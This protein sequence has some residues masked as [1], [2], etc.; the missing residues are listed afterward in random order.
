MFFDRFSTDIGIDLGTCNTL[1]YVKG[2]GIVIDEP[3]VIA[4]EKGT[5]RVVAVGAEAKRMLWK[6]PSNITAIRPL[7][8]GVIADIDSTEKM[9]KYFINKIMPRHKFIKSMRMKI[10]IPSCITEVERR[11]VIEAAFKAGAKEVG[12]IEESLAAAI[13][14]KIPIY[15]PAGHMVCDIGGGTTEVSVISLGGMVITSSIR[16]GGDK[17]D[18]AIVKHIRNVHNLIIGQ[19]TSER[20]K[21]E[22]GNASPDTNNEKMEIKGTDAVTGLPRPLE[23]D[24]VEVREALKEPVDRIIEEIKNSL[25]HTPPELA[26]DIV[27]RGIVMTGGGSML[28]GLP[29]LISRVT[30]VPVIL[31]EKPL[32]C[33]AMGAGESFEIFKDMTGGRSAYDNLNE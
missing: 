7:A 6:T 16:V 1:I 23:I 9:I 32:D 33:V 21:I 13:G 25:G 22:I 19:H 10:G 27:E 29:K 4:V 12:V 5:K 30:G 24:S 17:F 3:S 26:A 28:K 18:E 14:A 15:E 8:D 20:L 31:V 2:R 11:A